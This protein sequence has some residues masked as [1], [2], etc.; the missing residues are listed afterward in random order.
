MHKIFVPVGHLFLDSLASGA[1]FVNLE[2]EQ[3]ACDM[4]IFVASSGTSF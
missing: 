4:V 3:V 2:F 1:D